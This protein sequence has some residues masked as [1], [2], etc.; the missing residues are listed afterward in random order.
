MPEKSLKFVFD[1]S[2]F[3]Y[4][5]DTFY[6]DKSKIKVW[7]SK[8]IISQSDVDNCQK[9]Y[10]TDHIETLIDENLGAVAM[11]FDGILDSEN[12]NIPENDSSII[13]LFSIKKFEHKLD[14]CLISN[15][16]LLRRKVSELGFETKSISEFESDMCPKAE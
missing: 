8:V 10:T 3:Q 16:V 15:N 4:I 11:I 7:I 12:I 2:V 9:I 14:F 5:K 1:F 6:D 13:K